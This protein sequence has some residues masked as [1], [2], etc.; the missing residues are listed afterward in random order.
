MM[1]QINLYK[2]NIKKPVKLLS[3]LQMVQIISGLVLLLIITTFFMLYQH[4]SLKNDIKNL[5]K[6]Q[7]DKE[8]E[9]EK[10]A[11]LLPSEKN[12]NEL[13]LELKNLEVIKS[14]RLQM[15]AVLSQIE[16]EKNFK[17]S[18][19]FK[20]FSNQKIN[21][22]WLTSFN[23]KT[24]DAYILIEGKTPDPHFLPKLIENLGKELV[25]Q[26]KE[27]QSLKFLESDKEKLTY[28]ILQT[29][30]DNKKNLTNESNQFS[31]P[32]NERKD[33]VK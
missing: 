17:L 13:N 16:K 4:H 32:M 28:F 19:Y 3:I 31:P 22:I 1:Q 26:G 33:G 21:E 15:Q 18:E 24:Q 30:S 7:K 8:A 29:K 9:L 11:I 27:F 12:L 25:F 2:V 14:Q 10:Q 23:F 6:T 5:E 20:A